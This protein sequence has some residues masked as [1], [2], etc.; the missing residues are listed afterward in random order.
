[1]KVSYQWLQEYVGTAL[2]TPE[3]VAALLTQHAFEIDGVTA[4]GDDMVLDVDVLPNRSSDCLCH[5]GIARELASILGVSLAHDPLATRPE[6]PALANHIAITITDPVAC[7]RFSAALIT[8]VRVGPSPAWLQARLMA[9]GQ[10]S[11]NNIVD[12]TNYVMYAIGQPL[13]AYDAERFVQTAGQWQFVVRYAQAG[14]TVSL[15][16]EGGATEDRVVPLQGTELLIVDGATDTPIGLA[17]VKGGRYAGVH[18]GTTSIIVEA[19]H[20]NPTVVRRTAR[21]LGIVIDASKRFENEPAQTLPRYAQAAVATLIAEIAGGTFVGITETVAAEPPPVVPVSVR[22]ARV[23]QVLGATLSS[24]TVESLLIR[25]GAQV[26][27]VPSGD[28]EIFMV[29]S[30]FERTDLRIEE[31]YIEEVGRLYG[32][33]MVTAVPPKTGVAAPVHPLQY[34][35]EMIRQTLIG[36]GFSEVIT[37][38]FRARADIQLQNALASDKSCVRS[39]LA[40]QLSHV[41]TQNFPQVDLLGVD[42]VRVF[43]I[44]TVFR[45]TSDS[46]TEHVSL[47]LGCRLKGNGPSPKDDQAVARAWTAVLAVLNTV[48]DVVPM[49]G[50]IEINLSELIATLPQPVAYHE[51]SARVPA[52]F[53]PVNPLP[54]V[55]RDIALWVPE[56]TAAEVVETKLRQAAGAWCV[57]STLFDTFTKDGQTSYG[58][59]L[60]FQAPDRTLTDPE[61][62]QVMDQVYAT[63]KAAQYVVR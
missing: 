9:L 58:F 31:D 54:A 28:E 2:P 18:E 24:A 49:A 30:P 46:I 48:A 33:D 56:G 5:R 15:L 32:L 14:E 60:V 25:I 19:A 42:A 50:V 8:G 63:A 27:V 16:P 35:S 6:L 39:Q 23:N 12:A 11:I 21:R 26:A 7:P 55:A 36:H 17:G 22:V 34:Y 59:R 13:H 43:E 3:E 40:D 1:M 57:R 45:R 37:S 4:I 41:L 10:R 52:Q 44:G 20:F 62:N 29:T 38:S 53:R 51:V 61:V 47:A